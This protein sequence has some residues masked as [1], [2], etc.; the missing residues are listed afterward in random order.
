MINGNKIEVNQDEVELMREK[1]MK[2]KVI[3]LDAMDKHPLINPKVLS[4]KDN[5]TLKKKIRALF[6]TDLE[7]L[8]NQFNE[9][10]Q[11]RLFDK[12]S[13]YSN[14]TTYVDKRFPKQQE[15]YE[16]AEQAVDITPIKVVDEQ[17]NE[18]VIDSTVKNV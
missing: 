8:T 14:Y 4:T 2:C 9:V 7:E 3:A 12:D 11:L 18:I 13:D 6:D 1:L 16:Q 15:L 17:G 10:C 5:D